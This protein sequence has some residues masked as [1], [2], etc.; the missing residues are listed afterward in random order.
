MS[1]G[2]TVADRLSAGIERFRPVLASARARDL[3]VAD[4]S[5]IVTS[6]LGELFGYDEVREI[7]SEPG[8]AGVFRGLA[9]RVDGTFRMIVEVGAIGLQFEELQLKQAVTRAAS[10]GTEWAVL[11]NGLVW[12]VYRVLPS[13]PIAAE[14][15]L[16]IDLLGVDPR[17]EA[18]MS[19]LYLLTRESALESGLYGYHE[20]WRDSSRFHLAAVV[21]IDPVVETIGRELRR[22]SDVKQELD[23]LGDALR[24]E[25][26]EGATPGR[27]TSDDSRRQGA[28]AAHEALR[29]LEDAN[30]L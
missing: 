24:R 10:R 3:D 8:G 22:L 16:D 27:G 28:R 29:S 26:I 25:G 30:P 17:N 15:V 23:T 13:R 14:H 20:R 12:T 2:P 4:T 5:A 1:Y 11:T 18:H 21:M 6:L 19:I 9:T 7:T